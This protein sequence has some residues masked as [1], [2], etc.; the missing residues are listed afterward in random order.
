MDA[1]S[2][3]ISRCPN[4]NALNEK[5]NNKNQQNDSFNFYSTSCSKN[6]NKKLLPE[7]L[8][9]ILIYKNKRQMLFEV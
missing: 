8:N 5:L 4:Q 2:L 1:I 9:K 7:K 6:S 3:V